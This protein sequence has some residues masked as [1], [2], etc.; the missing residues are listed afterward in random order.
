MKLFWCCIAVTLLAAVRGAIDVEKTVKHVQTILKSNS[1]LPKLSRDEILQLLNDI[2]E[3]DS[4]TS[5]VTKLKELKPGKVE[6]TT[7]Y[8][9]E[10]ENEVS[11]TDHL[12]S[13]EDSK[14]YERKVINITTTTVLPEAIESTTKTSS[15]TLT[16]VLPYTPRDGASLQELY[17]RPPRVEVVKEKVTPAPEKKTKSFKDLESSLKNNAKIASKP[18]YDFPAE[19]QA[20]LVAHGLEGN[21]VK[22]HFLLPLDG[23]KPLPPAKIVDGNVQLPENILLTYDLVSPS[24]LK[25][26]AS[27]K[28]TQTNYLYEPLRPEFPFELETSPSESKDTVLPLDLP[29]PRNGKTITTVRPSSYEPIDYDSIKV[30]P[31]NSGP[32]PIDQDKLPLD[33]DPSK[34]QI[35][36]T[37]ADSGNISNIEITT[38]TSDSKV[39][40]DTS[41]EADKGASI[42]DLEDSFGGPL[43]EQP[44][45]SMIPPPKKNGF[46]WML[47]WN[48]FLEVGDGDSKVNIRFEPKLGDPQMFLPVNVP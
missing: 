21:P 10:E 46:Y 28:H 24:D 36:D 8:R 33:S 9:N 15:Q 12:H 20:F 17:T 34:R 5:S 45:D 35:N 3:E 43:P 29:K 31:L 16:V 37:Q 48:S 25:A 1:L 32:D 41:L 11:S 47:D 19:L 26:S 27:N 22:D 38:S 14:K 2:R 40:A 13:S 18:K 23:F 39:A 30:I 7:L 42:A 44:G 6:T 4:K